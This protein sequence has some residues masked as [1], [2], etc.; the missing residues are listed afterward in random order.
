MIALPLPISTWQQVS[1]PGTKQETKVGNETAARKGGHMGV[2]GSMAFL[3]QVPAASP[4]QLFGVQY[5]SIAGVAGLAMVLLVAQ[6][7]V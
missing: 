1:K 4:F 6:S 7:G 3:R 5:S 2:C